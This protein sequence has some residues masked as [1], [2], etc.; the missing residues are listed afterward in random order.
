MDIAS[1]YF[2]CTDAERAAFEAGIKFGTIYHQFVGTP[3]SKE[4]VDVLEKAIEEGARVQP[5]VVDLKVKIDRTSLRHKDT[6][7]DYQT[8]TG[9][10]LYV[11]LKVKYKDVEVT[12]EMRN[13]KEINYPL[14]FIKEVLKG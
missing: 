4:N 7:Y 14:M 3:L 10:M 5:F 9:N 2:N 8:L 11:W 13:I 12:C 1:N 6:D